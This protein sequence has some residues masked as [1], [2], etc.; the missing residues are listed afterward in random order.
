MGFNKGSVSSLTWVSTQDESKKI[1]KQ[2]RWQ[3]YVT[4]KHRGC[5]WRWR[6]TG[7]VTD[8]A[9]A[10]LV[11]WSLELYKQIYTGVGG[12]MRWRR[13][14]GFCWVHQEKPGEW[15]FHEILWRLI[16]G[17]L[18]LTALTGL[19]LTGMCVFNVHSNARQ[20]CLKPL[21]RHQ[22]YFFCTYTLILFVLLYILC[23][24]IILLHYI[25]LTKFVVF[26]MLN[27]W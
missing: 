20:C 13:A 24:F 17:S 23:N 16:E 12:G 6:L 9:D 14:G 15:F 22:G 19:C 21:C 27:I 11:R 7:W 2:K 25:N 3:L 8:S 10:S 26:H 1:H 4:Q 18:Q 5:L